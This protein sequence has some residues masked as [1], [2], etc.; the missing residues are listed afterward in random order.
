MV[1]KIS[2]VLFTRLILL[3]ETQGLGI[4]LTGKQY[5]VENHSPALLYFP[6]TQ[7]LLELH[8]LLSRKESFIFSATKGA[9]G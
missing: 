1:I 6:I 7:N 5:S 3:N 4:S 8:F 2:E 9:Q